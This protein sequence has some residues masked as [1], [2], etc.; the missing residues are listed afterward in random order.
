MWQVPN[1]I[2]KPALSKNIHTEFPEG[3]TMHPLLWKVQIK[4]YYSI[5]VKPSHG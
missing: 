4:Y 3:Y 1:P 2:Q 5:K